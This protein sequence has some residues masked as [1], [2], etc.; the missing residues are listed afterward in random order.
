M[1]LRSACALG[2]SWVCMDMFICKQPTFYTFRK[3]MCIC[4]NATN[5]HAA[6]SAMDLAELLRSRTL[7]S[8]TVLKEPS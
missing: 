3:D 7:G 6:V 5:R 1:Q 8:L 4:L 2:S